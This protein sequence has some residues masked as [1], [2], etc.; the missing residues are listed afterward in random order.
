MMTPSACVT[1]V[2]GSRPRG[3]NMCMFRPG[4][5]TV[6]ELARQ[7]LSSVER[8][9][10][11]LAPKFDLTPFRT[12]D[13]L[14]EAVAP[15]IGPPR[16]IDRALDLC[17]GTGAVMRVLQPLCREQVVGVDFSLGMLLEARRRLE[18]SQ[19]G[20]TL[21]FVRADALELGFD[22]AFDVITCFGALGHIVRR[23][24]P[25]VL[26][27]VAQALVPGGRFIF[28]SS[29]WPP[30]W[31][32]RLWLSLGFNAAMAVR[33]AVW[34]P[35]FVMYYLNFLLPRARRL[36][37]EHGFG[38]EVYS[39]CDPKHPWIDLVVA[40]RTTSTRL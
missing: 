6:F 22:A 36:L 16:S 11:L 9:Y 12:H 29:A 39:G 37:E 18:S 38:V 40:T 7:A 8:G 31:S 24:Q 33:N 21:R 30:P 2:G 17:C 35:P 1:G 10:D 4:G 13:E 14:L 32:P 19:G 26:R 5:P 27:G 3:Q 20:A 25:R 28:V 34:Q 23:Q 15:L